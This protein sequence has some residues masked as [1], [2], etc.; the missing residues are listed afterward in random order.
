MI[1]NYPNPFNPNTTFIFKIRDASHVKI[2]VF[3]MLGQKV[4]DVVDRYYEAGEH[5]IHWRAH[6][7]ISSGIY[8]YELQVED[9][10]DVQKMILMR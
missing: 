7:T 10:R 5:E 6:S 2:T 1:G 3:N 4:V 9:F 8:F